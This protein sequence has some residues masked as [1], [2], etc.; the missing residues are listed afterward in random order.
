MTIVKCEFDFYCFDKIVEDSYVQYLLSLS[1]YSFVFGLGNPR[2]A[3]T[4]DVKNLLASSRLQDSN[5]LFL[6]I[7]DF[8]VPIVDIF[9]ELS[10]QCP[11]IFQ[12]TN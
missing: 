6:A 9:C 5:E 4:R 12:Q 3:D 11:V 2:S 10:Y 7:V 1:P 8:A